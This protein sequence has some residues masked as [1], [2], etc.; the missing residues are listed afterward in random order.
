MS[1]ESGPCWYDTSAALIDC[2]CSGDRKP[3]NTV[4]KGTTATR[5]WKNDTGNDTQS[6][7]FRKEGVYSLA[8]IG[9]EH[10]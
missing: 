7:G 1:L 4:V 5:D 6:G 3:S 2:G 10:V 8:W 9:T